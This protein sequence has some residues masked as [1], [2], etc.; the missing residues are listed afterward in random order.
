MSSFGPYA[1][2]NLED[3]LSIKYAINCTVLKAVPNVQQF[4]NFVTRDWY[5]R[6]WTKQ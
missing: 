2:S 4:L 3:A 5:T 1:G 6:C